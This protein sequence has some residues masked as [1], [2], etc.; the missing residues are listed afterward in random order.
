MELTDRPDAF[1]PLT[2]LIHW[3]VAGL[4]V[5]LFSIAWIFIYVPKG[6]THDFLVTIHQSLGVIALTLGVIRVL[7]RMVTPFPAF[8]AEMPPFE[9]ALARAVQ[10]MLYGALIV[11]P[12]AGWLFANADGATVTFFG[13]FALPQLQ[14]KD[15]AVRDFVWNFHKEGGYVI[16]GLL[17]LHVAGAL[18]HH[19]IK[20]DGLL[21]GMLPERTER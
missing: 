21:R 11:I 18:R 14:P 9:R 6:A 17:A 2:K 5:L 19:F 20:R 15:F 13:L 10:V 16:L 8:P 3:L 7:R 12:C 1:G 4:V